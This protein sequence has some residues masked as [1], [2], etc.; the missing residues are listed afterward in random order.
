MNL[1]DPLDPDAVVCDVQIV[2]YVGRVVL[3]EDFVNIQQA[4]E[5]TGFPWAQNTLQQAN[6]KTVLFTLSIKDDN[7]LQ[8]LADTAYIFR[9]AV[10][11]PYIK[12]KLQDQRKMPA[13]CRVI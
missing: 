12:A 10:I 5:D 2:Q 9:L 3:S 6:G 8:L 13:S 7:A 11:V 1:L 4:F